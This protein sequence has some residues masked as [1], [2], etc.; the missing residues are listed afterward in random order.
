MWKTINQRR[1]LLL[2]G[3]LVIV[4]VDIFEQADTAVIEATTVELETVT[5]YPFINPDAKESQGHATVYSMTEH[6]YWP[7]QNK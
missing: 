6:R 5:R 3:L 1:S 4:L 7:A 2:M